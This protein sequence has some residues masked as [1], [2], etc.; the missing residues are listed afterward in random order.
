MMFESSGSAFDE[1][2]AK[3]FLDEPVKKKWTSLRSSSTVASTVATM[4]SDYYYDTDDADDTMSDASDCYEAPS[5]GGGE[6][7]I[8]FEQSDNELRLS[9]TLQAIDV[10]TAIFQE[11]NGSFTE[12]HRSMSQIL[13]IQNGKS[14]KQTCGQLS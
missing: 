7:V 5:L 4:F 14:R 13:D 8:V 10:E 1:A 9:S 3:P 2:L 6:E 11:R 12:V